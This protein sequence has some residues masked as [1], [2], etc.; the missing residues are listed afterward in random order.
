MNEN[1]ADKA[2]YQKAGKKRGI[3]VEKT[4]TNFWGAN[5]PLP[6]KLRETIYP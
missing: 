4:Q 1:I 5:E 3:N 6:S 2:E